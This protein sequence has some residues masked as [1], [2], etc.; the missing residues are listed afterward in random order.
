MIGSPE[1]VH[2]GM[3][4]FAQETGADELMIVSHVYDHAARVRSYEIAA[5]CEF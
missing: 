5:A 4:R 2:H 1:T 3:R